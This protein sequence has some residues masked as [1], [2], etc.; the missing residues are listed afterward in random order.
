MLGEQYAVGFGMRVMRMRPFNHFGPGQSPEYILGSI[1]RQI[2]VAEAAGARECLLQT[3][4]P[5][6]AR[7]FTDVRDIIRAYVLAT[8]LEPSAYNVCRGKATPV[9][10]LIELASR[11]AEIAVRHEVDDSLL[12]TGEPR[13]LFGSAE[14]LRAAC[15]WK[16]EISI[17]RTVRET[18]AWWRERVRREQV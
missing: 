15:G 11:Y 13:I 3:G 4:D 5:T 6:S 2:A 7:D 8:D 14:R 1:A 12:R 17:E 10:E 16:P 18:L 9:G